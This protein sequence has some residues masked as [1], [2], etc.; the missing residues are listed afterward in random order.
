MPVTDGL[1]EIFA[2]LGAPARLVARLPLLSRTLFNGFS[3]PWPKTSYARTRYGP[4]YK[5][6]PWLIFDVRELEGLEELIN[7]AT[8]K[9]LLAFRKSQLDSFNIVCIIGALLAQVAIST[10]QLPLM[11]KT[12]YVC[13]GMLTISTVLGLMAVYFS[14]LQQRTYGFLD[15]PDTLRLWLSDGTIHQRQTVTGSSDSRMQSS[16]IAH[17]FLQ[18]PFEVLGIAIVCFLGGLGVYLGCAMTGNFELHGGDTLEGN[19]GIMIVFLV[20]VLFSLSLFGQLLGGKDNEIRRARREAAR[21]DFYVAGHL[22]V[23]RSGS[24]RKFHQALEEHRMHTLAGSTDAS[25]LAKA[26]E[27]SAAAHRSCAEVDAKVAELLRHFSGN[28]REHVM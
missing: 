5:L 16:V 24:P 27:K 13:H 20:S 6:R 3:N 10:L 19:R 14:C 26:L 23:Q 4:L 2:I 15:D 21:S 11:E 8:D 9:Q 18:A 28:A 12:H 22:D 7:T 25:E 1:L 17:Q